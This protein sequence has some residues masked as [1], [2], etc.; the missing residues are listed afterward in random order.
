MDLFVIAIL[1]LVAFLIRAV[2]KR[3]QSIDE[4]IFWIVL[5]IIF[6]VRELN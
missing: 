1:L 6:L 4:S 2:I 5:L 3:S